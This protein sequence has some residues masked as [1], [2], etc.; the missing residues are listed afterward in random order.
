MLF[1]SVPQSIYYTAEESN[2]YSRLREQINTY[3]RESL[4]AFITGNRDIE[5]EWDSYVKEFEKL[6]LPKYLEYI[7]KAYDRQYK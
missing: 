2:E 4:V 3:A 5:K 6:E 7:Q 1:R